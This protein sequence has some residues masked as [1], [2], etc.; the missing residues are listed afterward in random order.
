[1]Q[2]ATG[3]LPL[4]LRSVAF[5]A[6]AAKIVLLFPTAPLA[7]FHPGI[8]A[9]LRGRRLPLPDNH[10]GKLLP[11]AKPQARRSPVAAAARLA[12]VQSGRKVQRGMGRRRVLHFH[13]AEVSAH[14]RRAPEQHWSP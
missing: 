12:E 3:P 7:S 10:V 13:F 4:F 2:Q 9:N 14:P 6:V 11:A 1:M 5:V 8:Y